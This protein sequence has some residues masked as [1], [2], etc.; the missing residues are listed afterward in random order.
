M[1]SGRDKAVIIYNPAAGNHLLHQQLPEIQ[2]ILQHSFST[3]SV[4]ETKKD[5]PCRQLVE[6]ACEQAGTII[7]A[8]GDGT[9]YSIVNAIAGMEE[10]PLFGILPGG[11]CNDF[12][13]ALGMNQNP[14]EAARQ[15][16]QKR[17]RKVD[18]GQNNSHYFL[19]FWG[20]GLITSVSENIDKDL[21]EKFGRLSYYWSAAQ[22]LQQW[23]PFHLELSSPDFQYSG[24]ATMLLI[25]NGPYT[26]GIR[27]FFP[28]ANLQDGKLDV[29]LIKEPSL[30]LVWEIIQSRITEN[31]PE[32]DGFFSFQA[33]QLSISATP[34]Q[35]IDCDGE[36]EQDTPSV[37]TCLKHH[38][39]VYT[40]DVPF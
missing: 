27:P 31:P 39:E 25:A 4:L 30:K 16:A 24:D 28:H 29:L 2:R 40:G 3:V 18:A 21:K 7:G 10:R 35:A 12:S 23:E 9:I 8:G 15:I 5:I 20:I 26:G 32:G 37:I 22:T 11:T 38:L 36:K 33:D 13:R 14:L 1:N 34:V 17:F 19:N 6:K